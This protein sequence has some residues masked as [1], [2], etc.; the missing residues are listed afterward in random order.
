MASEPCSFCSAANAEAVFKVDLYK[1]IRR[2]NVFMGAIQCRTEYQSTSINISRCHQCQKMH[3]RLGWVAA[4]PAFVVLI[5]ALINVIRLLYLEWDELSLKT[6]GAI[7]GGHVMIVVMAFV[8]IGMLAM[9]VEWIAHECGFNT[10]RRAREVE[11]IKAMLADGWEVGK[12]PPYKGDDVNSR[13]KWGFW[14]E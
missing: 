11:P 5:A 13:Y 9:S 1:I 6:V 2:E 8:V 4:G 7:V 10:E 3:G 14:N 12:K